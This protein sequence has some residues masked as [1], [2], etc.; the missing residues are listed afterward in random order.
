[1]LAADLEEPA[2]DE[3]FMEANARQAPLSET[4]LRF[5][6]RMDLLR[7][8]PQR[9]GAKGDSVLLEED[10]FYAACQQVPQEWS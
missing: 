9:Q 4:I 2:T 3:D 7:I 8:R 5:S 10:L 6:T 1:M